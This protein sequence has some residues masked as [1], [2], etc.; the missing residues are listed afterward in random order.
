MDEV[1][2]SVVDVLIDDVGNISVGNVLVGTEV[3]IVIGVFVDFASD[4]A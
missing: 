2:D 4:V 3:D 1:V